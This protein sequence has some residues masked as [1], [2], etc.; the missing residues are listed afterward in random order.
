VTPRE[1]RSDYRTVDAV[2]KPDAK[3]RTAASFVVHAGH[4]GVLR[5]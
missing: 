3:V 4:A 5:V 1:W 2:T